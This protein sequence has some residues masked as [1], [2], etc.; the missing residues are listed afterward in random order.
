M[1]AES[2]TDYDWERMIV[3]TAKLVLQAHKDLRLGSEF[4]FGCSKVSPD[5][6]HY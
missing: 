5:K 4:V 2:L 6:L 1:D 3:V